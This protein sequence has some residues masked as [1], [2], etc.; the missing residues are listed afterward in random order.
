M[1]KAIFLDRDGT[2]NIE[3]NYLYR[4]EDFE[5][6]NNTVE[7][8][9]MLKDKEYY[10]IVITNQSGIGR[11]YYTSDDVNNLHFY[12]NQLLE[13]HGVKIDAF[14]FCPHKADEYCNCRKPNTSLFEQA[15]KSFNIDLT[16]SFVVGDKISDIEAAIKLGSKYGLVLTGHGVFESNKME[17][18]KNIFRDLYDFALSI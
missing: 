18:K 5:F 9:K 14:Y 3:K 8:L 2:I 1:K 7:A 4:K 10:L 15:A 11:G 17:N 12:I 6:I 16:N 13:N